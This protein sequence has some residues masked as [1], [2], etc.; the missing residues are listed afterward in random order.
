LSGDVDREERVAELR[1]RIEELEQTG[2]SAFGGFTRWDWAVCTLSGLV[3]P[4][5]AL[6]WFAG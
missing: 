3:L 2:D 4:A 5:L 6:W 1:R